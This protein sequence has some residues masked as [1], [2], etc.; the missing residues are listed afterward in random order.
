MKKYI[1]IISIFFLFTSCESIFYKMYGIKK[2]DAFNETEYLN[3]V[4]KMSIKDSSVQK[5]SIISEL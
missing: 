3:S 4:E 2:M 5:T 1:T